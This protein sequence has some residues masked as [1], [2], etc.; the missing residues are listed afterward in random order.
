MITAGQVK[1]LREATGVGMMECKKALEECQGDM[2]KALT[3]LREKGLAKAAKK[4]GRVAAEGVVAFTIS[5]DHKEAAIIELNCETDFAGK[6]QSF[7]EM[8]KQLTELVL[9]KKLQSVDDV[10]NSKL[11]N[12]HKVEDDLV[13]LVSTIGENINLRRV[14]YVSVS[15]G[16]IVG[17]N[18]MQGKI[19]TLVIVE[20]SK[21]DKGMEV[22]SDVAMHVAA[23]APRYLERSQVSA[24]ELEEERKILRKQILEQGKPEQM[25]DKILE[26]QMNKFYADACLLD[27]PFV[28]EPK[29]S[30]SQ[31]LKNASA[32]HKL[33]KFVRFQLGE[34]IEVTKGDFQHEVSQLVK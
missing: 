12:G 27:Q 15:N 1:E 23:A 16:F 19:G 34:G 10:K 18:H 17:Y 2:K 26:G 9:T 30:V 29:L 24:G 6:N 25:V 28:K 5:N 11:S 3:Y 13:N 20:G 4:S 33:T 8:S 21:D 32:A 31:Y 7:R 22:A 14:Q